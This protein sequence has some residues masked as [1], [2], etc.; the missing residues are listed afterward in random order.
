MYISQ[1]R[2]Y[3]LPYT[4]FLNRSFCSVAWTLGQTD[5]TTT[6]RSSVDLFHHLVSTVKKY[7]LILQKNCYFQS[8]ISSLLDLWI[9]TPTHS[10]TYVYAK[11]PILFNAHFFVLKHGR[12]L[13]KIL[14]YMHIIFPISIYQRQNW[15]REASRSCLFFFYGQIEQK[16]N[17]K[18]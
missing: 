2:R 17:S 14:E 8:F 15:G 7:F 12:Y 1:Q 6:T 10:T 11:L 4:S 5:Y 9:F 13:V 3:S 16:L 18:M